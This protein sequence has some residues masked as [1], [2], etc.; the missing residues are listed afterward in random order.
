MKQGDYMKKWTFT[1][2]MFSIILV[3][4]CVW[5][6][7]SY[8]LAAFGRDQIAESLSQGVVATIIGTFVAYCC[9]SFFETKAEED[10]KIQRELMN[11]SG[12]E[13]EGDI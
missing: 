2:I 10:V 7:M 13:S 8:I 11:Y 12:E 3:N 6:Y 5:I 9:K 1:K 4:S